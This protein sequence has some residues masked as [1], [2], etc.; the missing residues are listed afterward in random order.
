LILALSANI[1]VF[2]AAQDDLKDPTRP[3][4]F[5]ESEHAGVQTEFVLNSVIVTDTGRTAVINGTRVNE[6]QMVNGAEV[7]SIE[8]GRVVMKIEGR[9]Q[10]LKVHSTRVRTSDNNS[11]Q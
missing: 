4:G 8:S 9:L 2:A 3:L 1:T 5:I 10:E 6:K 7:I 11:R